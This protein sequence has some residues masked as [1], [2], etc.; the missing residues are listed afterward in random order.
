MEDH[1][2]DRFLEITPGRIEIEAV[3][4]REGRQD[5]LA[6]VASR[7][8]PRKHHALQDRDAGVPEHEVGVRLTSGAEPVA[9]GAHPERRVERELTGLEFL[10]GVAAEGAG[11]LLREEHRLGGPPFDSVMP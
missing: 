3:R 10:E 8:P 6:Q 7:L 1:L 5:R 11:K 2:P 9:I 4:L